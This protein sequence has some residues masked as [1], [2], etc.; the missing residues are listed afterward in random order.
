MKINLDEEVIGL[1]NVYAPN[2]NKE[3][4]QIRNLEQI[5]SYIGKLGDIPLFIGDFNVHRDYELD[6]KNNHAPQ[7]VV[8][9]RKALLDMIES[10]EL[11]EIWRERHQNTCRYTFHRR[12]Q[13]SRVDLCLVSRYISNKVSSCNVEVS[14]LSDH[15]PVVLQLLKSTVKRGPGM[16]KLNDSLLGKN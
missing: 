11:T 7:T 3:S 6:R 5:I 16:W 14:H 4:E 13:A 9:Y 1:V 15:S 8:N 12:Y 10:L 2:Q